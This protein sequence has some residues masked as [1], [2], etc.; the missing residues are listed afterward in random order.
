[1]TTPEARDAAIRE[2][3]RY[4]REVVRSDWVFEPGAARPYPP[5]STTE[6]GREVAEW[7]LRV[8]DSSGSELEPEPE[9]YPG[10]NQS[11]IVEDD[12]EVA[13]ASEIAGDRHRKRRRQMDEEMNWNAGLRTWME[14]RDAWTGARTRRSMLGWKKKRRGRK[15][16]KKEGLAAVASASAADGRVD[17]DKENGALESESSPS[18]ASAASDAPSHDRKEDVEAVAAR[19]ETS[20]SLADKEGGVQHYSQQ[21]QQSQDKECD[22]K[23]CDHSNPDA[24]EKRKESSETAITEPDDDSTSSDSLAESDDDDD[25]DDF[26]EEEEKDELDEPLIP[27]V[28]SLISKTNPIRA[29]ITQSMYPSI[30]SK[31]VV[32]GLTPT[33]PINLADATKAM[34]QGWKSDGQWPSKPVSHSIVLQDDAT[35][36]RQPAAPGADGTAGGSMETKRRRSSGVANAVR[37]VLHFSGHPFHRRGASHENHDGAAADGRSNA[38]A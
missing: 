20:L 3:K 25:D 7:R 16:K 26:E 37:K 38:A 2:A 10:G 22:Q 1:M 14:R 11:A 27:I 9:P 15:G 8:Y 13:T 17:G 29:S 32:Q 6:R 33:V 4:I 12:G 30:Y 19:T 31:V 24:E 35:V 34:V 23:E 21:A 36:P 18:A 5:P 28:P